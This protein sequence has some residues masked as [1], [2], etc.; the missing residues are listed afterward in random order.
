[1]G[2][3]LTEA[4]P[5]TLILTST[6]DYTGVTTITGGTLIVTANGAM[7]P[8]SD[9]GITVDRG[10][11]LG[12]AGG[13]DYTTAEPLTI[14]GN[15]PK[16]NG[17]LVN[18][19]DTNTL[20]IPVTFSSDAAIGSDSGTLTVSGDVNFGVYN[21]TVTG[22]GIR[23]SPVSSAERPRRQTTTISGELDGTYFNLDP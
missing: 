2:R 8:A 15:G 19:S 17:E 5:G 21:L 20:A 4:G 18:I 6:N 14:V 16:G 23:R 12:F 10:G 9:P 13:V 22:S 11:A 3:T 1:M 7:G